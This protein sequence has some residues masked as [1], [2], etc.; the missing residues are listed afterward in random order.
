MDSAPVLR[1]LLIDDDVELC[2]LLG[3]YL[4]DENFAVDA[5]NDPVQGVARAISGHYALVLLDVMMPRIDGFETLRRIRAGSR[6][7]VLM[8]TAKGDT[9]DRVLGLDQ[10]AD[11]YLAKPFEPS[12]LAARVRA[13]LRRS[14]PATRTGTLTVADIQVDLGARVIRRAGASLDLTSVEFDLLTALMSAAGA[15]VSRENLMLSVLGRDLSPFDR[16]IDTHVYNLR[17]KIGALPDGTE[18]IK[19]IRGSGYYYAM[20]ASVGDRRDA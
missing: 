20:P 18:R 17:K 9:A 16:S 14:A 2:G 5:E 10:G 6:V 8:L 12:E 11:D 19:S 15:P 4:A 13:I 3:R 1:L 7:P